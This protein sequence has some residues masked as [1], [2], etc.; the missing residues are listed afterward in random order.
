[1]APSHSQFV[2]ARTPLSS[3]TGP[4]LL[5]MLAALLAGCA[6]D[7]PPLRPLPN[8]AE[9]RARIVERMPA[10]VPDR[11][12]WAT[13][14]QAALA[15][16][17][18]DPNES[19]L[20]AVLAVTA[21][22]SGFVVDPKVPGMARIAWAEIDRRAEGLGLPATLLHLALKLD[23]PNGKTYADRIDAAK[24]ERDLSDV[25][26]D[27]IS[28]VP[29]GQRLFGGYN[30]VRTAGPMQVQIDFARQHLA[31]KPYPYVVE[32]SLRDEVFSRRGGLYFGIAHLLDYPA[33]YD[34]PIHRFADY[35]AGQYA[36][37][38]A[39]FQQAVSSV[40]GI[41][42]VADGDLVRFDGD[43][44]R[45]GATEVAV[46]SIADRLG[47]DDRAIRD[48][49]ESGSGPDFGAGRLAQRVY[50]LADAIKGRPLP[51]ASIPTIKLKS[52]KI[53]RKLTTD[54]FATRVQSRWE[55]CM[56]VPG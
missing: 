47:M 49:L 26:D 52:P 11:A 28:A 23:S 50:A 44:N 16:L 10:S 56:A 32:G 15:A 1:M 43:R 37:R 31:R 41:P 36:S 30:P 51:R 29:L 38:N 14:I 12:G 55:R 40:T 34:Q 39:A 13:D 22:E 54:W 25:F 48:A 33:P 46:R 2:A 3:L 7:A 4:A 19:N 35:N 8:P 45:P 6:S 24:T 17:K 53:Q 5:A 21:Q 20:C 42:L 18:I 9:V 27:F